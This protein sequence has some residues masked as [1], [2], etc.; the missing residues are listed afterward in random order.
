MLETVA[1]DVNGNTDVLG[2]EIMN[3]PYPG[4]QALPTLLGSPF[5]DTEELTPF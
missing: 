2:Y 5:F 1:G 3:E 4:S